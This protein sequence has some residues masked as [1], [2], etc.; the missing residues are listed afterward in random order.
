MT[1]ASLETSQ[2]DAQPFAL[3]DIAIGTHH[4]Y[5]TNADT[6]INFNA[7]VWERLEGIAHEVLPDALNTDRGK[8]AIKL[9]FNHEL[10]QLFLPGTPGGSNEVTIWH[11][12][13]G[14]SEYKRMWQGRV[15]EFIVQLPYA[16]LITE[17]RLTSVRRNVSGML[18][19]TACP[20]PVFGSKCGLNKEDYRTNATVS[21]VTGLS[22]VAAAFA[23]KPDKYLL[24]GYVTWPHPTLVGV[25]MI[26]NII[27]HVGNTITLAMPAPS[28]AAGTVLAAYPG[29]NHEYAGDCKNKFNNTVNFRGAPFLNNRNP[30][31]GFRLY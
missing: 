25:E 11:G 5:F 26:G 12:H 22:I 4:W 18:I 7:H 20:V 13:V 23:T 15:V 30:F 28:I 21:S 14:S 27:D 24:G 1:F 9:P 29:C 16:S 3:F 6:L 31:D 10:S 2:Y 8:V 19:S 17:S